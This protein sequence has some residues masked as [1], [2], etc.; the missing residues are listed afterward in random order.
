MVFAPGAIINRPIDLVGRH[1]HEAL[2]ARV[3]RAREELLGAHDI[4]FEEET[5]S[6]D[7]PVDVTLRGEVQNGV[8]TAK[9]FFSDQGIGDASFDEGNA[10]IL[11]NLVEILETTR[12]RK[13]VK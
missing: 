4:R 9:Y 3:A 1:V 5:R 11:S 2:D 13:C 8:R 7:G 6:G 10:R 12:V